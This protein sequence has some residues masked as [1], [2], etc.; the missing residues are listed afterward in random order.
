M[1]SSGR[2]FRG[3][4]PWWESAAVLVGVVVGLTAW[5]LFVDV[6]E[7]VGAPPLWEPG[8]TGLMVVGTGDGGELRVY[9]V[10]GAGECAAAREEFERLRELVLSQNEA[11]RNALEEIRARGDS[12]LGGLPGHLELNRLERQWWQE[13]EENARAWLDAGCP[14]DGVRGAMR[15]E[16]DGRAVGYAVV[17]FPTFY[18]WLAARWDSLPEW[19]RTWYEAWHEA[20]NLPLLPPGTP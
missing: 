12:L 4:L 14:E 15:T 5:L 3:R 18:H 16:P 20:L 7:P 6:R 8:S 19:F 10:R 2:S 1:A 11:D 17:E 9:P 13:E